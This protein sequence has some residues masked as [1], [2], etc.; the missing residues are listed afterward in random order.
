[1][2]GVAS[3]RFRLPWAA[4][5][6]CAL[7]LTLALY[8]ANV[9]FGDL[10]QDEGWYLYAAQRV[11]AGELPYRDFHFSQGPLIPYV[12]ASLRFLWEPGGVLGGRAVTAALG[13]LSAVLAALLARRMAP[14]GGTRT[15]ALAAFA[16][17]GVN[18]Y[19]SYFT[20]I[21]KSYSLTAAFA[22]A[23]FLALSYVGGRR[24]GI[25]AAAGAALL[26]CAV[27][28]RFSLIAAFPPVGL[29]LL[30]QRRRLGSPLAWV[31]FVAAGALVGLAVFGPWLWVCSDS[32]LFGVGVHAG[33]KAGDLATVLLYKAGFVSRFV[34][35]YSF[36]LLTGLGGLLL[37]CAR[38]EPRGC[39]ERPDGAPP[40]F[41]LMLLGALALVSFLHLAAAVPYDDYQVPVFPLMAAGV[42]ALA[43]HALARLGG[44]GPPGAGRASEPA[45]VLLALVLAGCGLAAFGSPMNQEWF[46]HG[47]D[48]IWWLKKDR[49]QVLQLKQVAADLRRRMSGPSPL[50]LTQDIYLAVEGGFRVPPCMAMGPF[51]YF[52]GLSAGE[53]ARRRVLDRRGMEDLLRSTPAQMAA[54][55]GYSLGIQMPAVEP[56]PPDVRDGFRRILAER[57]ECVGSVPYFGQGY[58]TLELWQRKGGAAGPPAP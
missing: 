31:A 23:A 30:W 58:T 57:Y 36:A 34:R 52:P 50:L 28:T 3:S 2:D 39:P 45:A 27:G 8:G 47:R 55:S 12:Y 48:R 9:V 49:P 43:A 17:A 15:A 24:G 37:W 26:A 20:A 22:A 41:G 6:V 1:M 35:A 53:A 40:G 32:F 16:L 46:I 33:R 11:A 19:Q 44:E 5:W 4:L 42:A 51:S 18:V 29:Y 10:N 54:L 38:R 21:V 56:V 14:P 7:V 25:A 13:L